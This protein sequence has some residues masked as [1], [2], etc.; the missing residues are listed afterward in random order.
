MAKGA[1]IT[2]EKIKTRKRKKLF[3]TVFGS[4]SVLVFILAALSLVSSLDFFQIKDISVVGGNGEERIAVENI[5][6]RFL[7]GQSF[8]FFP[9]SNIFFFSPKKTA[10]EI[11]DSVST[12]AEVSVSKKLF[13]TVE[14]S[15]ADKVSAALWCLS[16]SCVDV[17]ENGVA[18]AKASSASSSLVVFK[19]G[20]APMLGAAPLSSGEFVPLLIFVNDLPQRGISASS[21]AINQDGTENIFVGTS[22]TFLKVD[23]SQDLSQTLD[24]L[25]RLL[26]NKTDGITAETIS[27]LEYL[28]LRFPDKI[29]YK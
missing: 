21:V 5:I 11:A 15:F 26:E 10:Q 22:T 13:S 1:P 12:A 18:F 27:S 9:H 14:V 8:F 29:F 7:A 2:Q 24:N 25:D 6:D 20:A 23:A 28:D 17:D 3:W 4:L 19:N 16:G